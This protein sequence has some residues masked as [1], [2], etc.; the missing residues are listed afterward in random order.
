MSRLKS[1]LEQKDKQISRQMDEYNGLRDNIEKL[2][3]QLQ[4]MVIRKEEDFTYTSD[5]IMKQKIISY[6]TGE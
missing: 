4:E 2:E 1:K 5:K 3:M 6:S